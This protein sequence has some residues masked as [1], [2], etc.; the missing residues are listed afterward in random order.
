V[1]PERGA[2]RRTTGRQ[3]RHVERR[4]SGRI[5]ITVH[6]GAERI[7]AVTPVRLGRHVQTLGRPPPL[8]TSAG[9]AP[10]VRAT[11]I[12]W[13]VTD[14][15]RSANSRRMPSRL[16]FIGASPCAGPAVARFTT[17]RASHRFN[18]GAPTSVG[19]GSIFPR[20]PVRL[21][22]RASRMPAAV[23]I[24]IFGV[25]PRA[26]TVAVT[27]LASAPPSGGVNGAQCVHDYG[28]YGY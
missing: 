2:R 19:T 6:V 23:R 24:G 11:R 28:F 22:E 7:V 15:M 1:T 9:S 10:P 14:R 8:R 26:E 25:A 18:S 4:R 13:R 21:Q 17:Y 27:S 3:P 5:D 12:S 20:E 16:S